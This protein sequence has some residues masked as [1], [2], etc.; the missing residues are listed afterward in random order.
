MD[1]L[2]E[3]LDAESRN[4]PEPPQARPPIGGKEQVGHW[5]AHSARHRVQQ[6]WTPRPGFAALPHRDALPTHD[7]DRMRELMLRQASAYPRCA[8]RSAVDQGCGLHGSPNPRA[9]D[10]DAPQGNSAAGGLRPG[11]PAIEVSTRRGPSAFGVNPLG[12]P[13]SGPYCTSST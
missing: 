5:Y 2:G 9:V 12:G 11:L 13:S 1:Q 6:L 10:S 7:P 8:E 4:K 3:F